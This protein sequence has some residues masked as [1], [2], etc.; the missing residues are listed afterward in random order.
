MKFLININ[1]LKHPR[2]PPQNTKHEKY[3]LQNN[4]KYSIN[5]LA[6]ALNSG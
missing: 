3:L 5:K 1:G 2:N 6:G 4:I